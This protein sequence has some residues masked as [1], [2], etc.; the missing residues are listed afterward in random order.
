M[1]DSE[2]RGAGI[3]GSFKPKLSLLTH[4]TSPHL[5]SGSSCHRLPH[6]IPE[7]VLH[8]QGINKVQR[9]GKPASPQGGRVYWQVAFELIFFVVLIFT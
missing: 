7:S 4:P 3:L 2:V 9:Q 8:V 5:C 1:S 6:A